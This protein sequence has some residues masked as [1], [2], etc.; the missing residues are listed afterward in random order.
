M[1]DEELAQ[2]VEEALT[3]R[4]GDY[5]LEAHATGSRLWRWVSGVGWVLKEEQTT[6]LEGLRLVGPS[7]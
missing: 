1:T 7:E 5:W 4:D 2:R 3:R 6:L